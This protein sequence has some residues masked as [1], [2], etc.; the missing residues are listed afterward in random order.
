MTEQRNL[1]QEELKYV[2]ESAKKR[3]E[4]HPEIAEKSLV[5]G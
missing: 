4:Y 2:Y 1:G 5:S 3:M